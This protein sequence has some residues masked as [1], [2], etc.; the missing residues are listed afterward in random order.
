MIYLYLYVVKKITS[1]FIVFIDILIN[2]IQNFATHPCGMIRNV[3]WKLKT[4]Y[5]S[6]N[7]ITLTSRIDYIGS[8]DRRY[9]NRELSLWCGAIHRFGVWNSTWTPFRWFQSHPTRLDGDFC[10]CR[11]VFDCEFWTKFFSVIY[12]LD[13]VVLVFGMT[14]LMCFPILLM[15]C[16]SFVTK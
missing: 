9:S 12:D 6:C 1:S 3:E 13:L 2:I 10:C 4:L 14:L 15:N 16:L 7:E 11:L 5:Y 8:T